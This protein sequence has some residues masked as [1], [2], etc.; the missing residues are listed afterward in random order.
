[1]TVVY[2]EYG[3]YGVELF[4]FRSK[5]IYNLP[6]VFL[7]QLLDL[8]IVAA[9]TNVVLVCEALSLLLKS[10]ICNLSRVACI[11]VMLIHYSAE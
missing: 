2:Y 8:V 10:I 9:V 11:I 1:M 3:L 6:V 7:C 5:S 4:N